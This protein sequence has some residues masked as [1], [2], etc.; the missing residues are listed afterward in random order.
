MVAAAVT[1]LSFTSSAI[2]EAVLLAKKELKLST[3]KQRSAERWHFVSEQQEEELCRKYVPKNTATFTKWALDNFQSWTK[4]RNERFAAVHLQEKQVPDN[5]LESTEDPA[6][7]CKWL[8]LYTA[9][10]RKKDGTKCPPKTIYSLLSGLLRHGR[11][12]NPR[13]PNFL[14]LDDH[15]F[16]K[17]H[18]AVDNVCRELRQSGVGSETKSAE[19]FTKEDEKQ[20]W[21]RG[22]LGMSTGS[23]LCRLLSEWKKTSA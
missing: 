16:V 22:V 9:E 5:L 12:Q 2:H 8:T 3:S 1:T 20:L 17:L 19:V 13:C 6:T 15:R 10:T 11:A 7:L 14:D 4:S 23:I 18:N 21:E